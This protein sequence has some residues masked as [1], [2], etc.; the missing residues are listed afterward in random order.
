MRYYGYVGKY[1]RI[2]LTNGT[3][4]IKPTPKSLARAFIGGSGF[5]ARILW[6]E[7]G[8][9]VDPLSPE[10]RLVIAT[11]PVTGTAWPTAG[12]YM[13]AAK[14]PLT[15]IWGESH[16][17]GHL[18][19][20]IKYAGFD[21]LVIEGRSPEPV[22][23]YLNDG[24]IEI[25]PAG[26]FWG[27]MVHEAVDELK[28]ETDL[29]AHVACIGPAGEKLVRFA[30]VISDY[31]R[32][33]GR[34]GMGAVW[35]SKRLKAL[36]VR[37]HGSVEVARFE[38]FM[39]IMQEAHQ[40]GVEHPQAQALA[41]YGT[42]LLV[43]YKQSIGE[44]PTK[45]HW[46][47][48]F[49]GAENLMAE[50]LKERYWVRTRACF[51]CRTRC[52]KV[53]KSTQEPYVVT[54]EGPEY[55]AIY[56]FGSNLGNDN[57]PSIL[58]ANY[59]CN[60][61]GLDAI[62]T[63]C[64]IAFL[65][66]CVEKGIVS[67]EEVDGLDLKWGN[68]EAFIELIH[69]IAKREGI[70]NLLAEGVKRAAEKIGRGAE[71][72][73]LHVKGM[74]VSGQDGRTHRSIG[75]S[76]AVASRGADHLRGLVTVDQLGYEEIAAER[77]GR[78]KLPEICNPYSEKWKA[79]AVKTTEDVYALRDTLIVCWYTVSWPPIYW[80]EDFARVLPAVTGED[81]FGKVDELLRI[82]ER[83]VNLERCFNVREGIT[84]KDDRLPER[85]TKEPMPQ[86][87]GKGQTV[88]LDIML[89]EYYDLR[90]WDKKTGIPKRETLEKLQLQKQ[91]EELA[92]MGKLP[93]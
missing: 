3:V 23:L 34:T 48:V 19:P 33:H 66:E 86:G 24:R 80:V 16:A 2:N 5:A 42:P 61:Y 92:R 90:G 58:Y 74:E 84:R 43:A 76:H 57:F 72:Y 70:G 54:S 37:G 78:D 45:N 50:T 82:G 55:E 25:L 64:T 56:S 6:D 11:G 47:G 60:Q 30:A 36:V 4:C 14:S 13:M 28:R 67:R 1:A 62:S 35:G 81:A 59:L 10:N 39:E 77:W 75:L 41:E 9:E 52:K 68:H 26:D 38:Q 12:R 40:R 7:V 53:Y 20:E 51:A 44:L 15:G 85:F 63:G 29:N 91:A 65:T 22:Y 83:I 27:L 89:D 69:K 21:F 18:G 88:N 31:H 46:T 93:T 49:D 87:P 71:Y 73:A 8:P 17:G 79:L 32:A